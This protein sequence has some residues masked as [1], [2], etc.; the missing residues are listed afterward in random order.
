MLLSTL[1]AEQLPRPRHRACCTL[2]SLYR[3]K[4]CALTVAN[5]DHVLESV[6]EMENQRIKR[7]NTIKEM[8]ELFNMPE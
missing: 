7:D 5:T 2:D 4:I 1:K 6:L 8:T 3:S